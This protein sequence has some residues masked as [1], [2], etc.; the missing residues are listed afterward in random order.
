MSTDLRVAF[1]GAASVQWGYGLT[2]DFIVT[3]SSD[4]LCANL[5]KSS[6]IE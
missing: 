1:L 2:R 3:L 6:G 5:T 4:S